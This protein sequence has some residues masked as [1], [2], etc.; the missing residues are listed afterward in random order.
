MSKMTSRERI[1][2]T[3]NH[4]EPDRVLVDLCSIPSSGILL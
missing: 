2:C 4:R 3:V 1:H